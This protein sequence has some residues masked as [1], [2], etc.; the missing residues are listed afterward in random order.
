[1]IRPTES[2]QA[3]WIEDKTRNIARL[4]N[5]AGHGDEGY[6]TGHGGTG[7]LS[8]C[9]VGPSSGESNGHGE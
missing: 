6:F 7:Q 5:V 2:I 9:S 3:G 8:D 4:W 1:M